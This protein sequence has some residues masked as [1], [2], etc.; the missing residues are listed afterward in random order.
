MSPENEYIK[1]DI[2][3]LCGKTLR[4]AANGAK[5]AVLLEVNRLD[6]PLRYCRWTVTTAVANQSVVVSYISRSLRTSLFSEICIDYV[7]I[8]RVNRTSLRVCGNMKNVEVHKNSVN[9]TLHLNPTW[10]ME[11]G[12]TPVSLY[13]TAGSI[14]S[15]L[16]PVDILK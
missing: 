1:K 3:D 4:L 10:L 9:F 8:S 2:T 16:P 6:H 7:Q 12:V 13:A 11:V 14:P 15:K 5:S